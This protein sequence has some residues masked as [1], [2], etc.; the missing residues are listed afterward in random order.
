MNNRLPNGLVFDRSLPSALALVPICWEYLDVSQ[1]G[2]KKL[3]ICKR[4]VRSKRLKP[5]LM[6]PWLQQFLTHYSKHRI[7]GQTCDTTLNKAQAITII[8]R[9]M[10]K[11]R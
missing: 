6:W 7:A 5:Y 2:S 8:V 4:R 10:P 9:N 1:R 11:I 3:V